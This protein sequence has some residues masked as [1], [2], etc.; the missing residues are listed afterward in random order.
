MRVSGGCPSCQQPI[1]TEVNS[2]A[3]S[4]Q[5]AACDWSR[6]VAEEDIT[7]N[8]PRRCLVCG[9]EDLWRQKDFPQK[10]GVGLVAIGASLST[11]AYYN[12]WHKTA[13]G[14]LLFFALIDLLL[15]TWMGDV[16]VCYRCGATHRQTGPDAEHPAFDL[17][18]AER[19]RQEAIRLAETASGNAKTD[20]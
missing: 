11:I 15:Y 19:Y 5:C 17:E 6:G 4:L 18:T 7:D 13:M 10:L 8:R 14:V 16:L 12:Y 20:E 3:D 9:C 1:R 2:V